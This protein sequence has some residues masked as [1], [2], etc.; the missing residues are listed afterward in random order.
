MM[1]P[2]TSTSTKAADF[3]VFW[4]KIKQTTMA[5]SDA[6]ESLWQMHTFKKDI[7]RLGWTR[8][9]T[10]CRDMNLV[11]HEIELI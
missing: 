6:T 7:K 4:K 11:A 8:Y 10:W 2:T 1:A 9:V 5:M 3:E